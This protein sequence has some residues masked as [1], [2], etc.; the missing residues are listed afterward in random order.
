MSRFDKKIKAPL[1]AKYPYAQQ[2][3]QSDEEKYSS[4][5][6]ESRQRL[7]KWVNSSGEFSSGMLGLV[8]ASRELPIVR[9]EV[10]VCR[11]E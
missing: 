3:A 2:K 7:R 4:D 11:D 1:P 9:R 6:Q 10:S 8:S 5:L